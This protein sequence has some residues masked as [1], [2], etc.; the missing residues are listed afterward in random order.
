M[1]TES[2]LIE[3]AVPLPV[4]GTFT[5]G[6]PADLKSRAT[7]GKMVLVPFGGRKISAYVLGRAD[8]DHPSGIKKVLT[9][10]DDVPLFPE[11]MI[12]F[13]RWIANYYMHP[14]GEVIK[15][16]LPGGLSLYDS[17]HI[18]IT[19]KGVAA[20]EKVR[21]SS[22]ETRLLAHLQ[23]KG[24]C[25]MKRLLRKFGD[26]KAHATIQRLEKKGW[27][28][29]E[30]VLG[31]QS[32]R[33][34]REC[35]LSLVQGDSGMGRISAARRRILSLLEKRAEISFT[36][37]K[38]QIPTAPRL[39]RAMQADGQVVIK[40]KEVYRDPFGDAVEPDEPPQPTFEQLRV[41][42]VVRKSLGTGFTTFLLAGVTGSGKTEIYLRLT[43]EAV[44]KGRCALILVPEIALIAQIGRRFRARFSDRVAVLH[45]GLS[46]GERYDQWQ[47]IRKGKVSIAIGARSAI[48]APLKN[49]GLIVVDEEHD[50]SYKQESKLRYNARDM[51]VM[52]AKFENCIAVLGSATPSVQSYYNCLRNK[53]HLLSLTKR[54]MQRPMPEIAVVDLSKSRGSMGKRRLL[55]T[56][57]LDAIKTTLA[58]G[59]QAL[60]FLNRR[61][62]AS[63]PECTD[64]GA[65]LK[66]KNCDIS[67][68]LHKQANAYRCHYCGFA[69]SSL[70]K[71][72]SC[73]SANIRLMGMGTEKIEN[74]I[75]KVFPKARV[76]RM[77]Q[78]TTRRKGAL[79]KILKDLK[80]EKIDILVGTQ[81]IAK[82]H[83]FPKITLVGIIC[84]DLSLNFPDF[85][86]GER[87]FQI[88][89]QVAGRAGRGDTPGR[90]I[91]QTYNPGHFSILAAQNQD[92]KLFY[93][94]EIVFREALGYPPFARM[95]QIRISGRDPGKTQAFVH[96]M[97]GRVKAIWKGERFF[98]ENLE[99]L[100]PIEAPLAKIARR[101]RWQLLVK[102]PKSTLV[103]GFVHKLTHDSTVTGNRTIRVTV[104]VDPI[105]ML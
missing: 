45:S 57:L 81:M 26:K 48:F 98:R 96:A 91:L 10:I 20:L 97:A 14:L 35:F 104:D 2:A 88:L 56:P 46:T 63:F 5:Y 40:E 65:V 38:Q 44:M 22:T 82:G 29:K 66:C 67:L 30:R 79:L 6:V 17:V 50:P 37:L 101:Y 36:D 12:P 105:S 52:R 39:A 75:T 9:V 90:V 1:K 16:A 89:A 73:G 77:D 7:A 68:T 32:V 23:N 3:V 74:I 24:H 61:G 78:D 53:F 93:D 94:H 62:F 33:P 13:Y 103:R 80:R 31:R 54:V 43:Q 21:P 51:A 87:T 15:S 11:S 100:G 34:K 69:R 70:T 8:E 72:Q 85:R 42:E 92:F 41:L 83:D 4:E 60:L 18:K 58:R 84:A 28:V 47:R 76:A 55:T 25:Q 19:S 102:G 86:A 27:L 59:E 95:I 49:I 64:C 99:I 71:C